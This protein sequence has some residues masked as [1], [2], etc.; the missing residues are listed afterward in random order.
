MFLNFVW[1]F[2]HFQCMSLPPFCPPCLCSVFS[3]KLFRLGRFSSLDGGRE[4]LL[5]FLGCWYFSNSERNLYTSSSN[6]RMLCNNCSIRIFW[7]NLKYLNTKFLHS[8]LS[9]KSILM[10]SQ[11][12]NISHFSIPPESPCSKIVDIPENMY[13]FVISYEPFNNFCTFNIFLYI[14]Q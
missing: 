1:R 4:L 8:K 14:A 9:K 3:R 10:T 2:N 12:V 11:I 13:F 7:S 5:L 6:M